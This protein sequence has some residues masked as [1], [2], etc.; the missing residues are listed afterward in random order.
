MFSIGGI[1]GS[2]EEFL[3]WNFAGKRYVRIE[4]CGVVAPTLMP[5]RPIHPSG[6]Y[7]PERGDAC[8]VVVIAFELERDSP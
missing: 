6:H 2:Y 4:A 1:D 5:A 7:S 8:E 3:G